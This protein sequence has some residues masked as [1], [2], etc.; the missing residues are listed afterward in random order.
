MVG[1]YKNHDSVFCK[2]TRIGSSTTII[3]SEKLQIQDHVYIGQYNFL[4]ASNS[5]KIEEGCQITSY[6][7]ILT[8][9]SHIS[10]RLYGDQYINVP[11]SDKVGY[12]RGPVLIGAYT[13]IGPHVVIMPGTKIGKGCIVSAFS[14][15]DGEYPDF[16]VIGGQ[17]AQ[18]L[19]STK[20]LDQPF[21]DQDEKLK[22]NYLNWSQKKY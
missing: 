22:S 19:K 13:F 2:N 4:D 16:S 7:S 11:E 3:Q 10:I 6:V 18:V 21:L 17:P 20:E 5:L 14:Y 9:S 15:L 1:G 12:K 8:H